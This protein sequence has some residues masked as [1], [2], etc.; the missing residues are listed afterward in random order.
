MNVSF[1]ISN[2]SPFLKKKNTDI[3]FLVKKNLRLEYFSH[4]YV[5]QMGLELTMLKRLIV[6]KC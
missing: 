4:L 1:E 6:L 5:Q 2:K 3:I